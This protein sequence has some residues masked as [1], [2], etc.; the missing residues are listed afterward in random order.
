M[1]FKDRV[2]SEGGQSRRFPFNL[3]ISLAHSA[4]SDFLGEELRQLRA[5][6]AEGRFSVPGSAALFRSAG[7]LGH[8]DPEKLLVT[9]IFVEH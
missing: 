6:S 7:R 1:G 4:V 5:G 3:E 2:S 9:T 8:G